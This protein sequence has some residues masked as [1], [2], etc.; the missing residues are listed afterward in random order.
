[1][2]STVVVGADKRS[3]ASRSKARRVPP[4]E[5]HWRAHPAARLCAN[6]TPCRLRASPC[7]AHPVANTRRAGAN[8]LMIG[9]TAAILRRQDARGRCALGRWGCRCRGCAL[10]SACAGLPLWASRLAG[11]SGGAWAG[12]VATR[13]RSMWADWVL[14]G[15]AA[16]RARAGRPG[17]HEN[18]NLAA[19]PDAAACLQERL[20]AAIEEHSTITLMVEWCSLVL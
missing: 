17:A 12:G 20:P 19:A 10:S 13:L 4:A 14:P 3:P 16:R 1:M 6:G 9:E 5:S 15:A 18:F 7:L 2:A 8:H 11:C